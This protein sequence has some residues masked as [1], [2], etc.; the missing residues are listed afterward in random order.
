MSI[1]AV[2]YVVSIAIDLMA[3]IEISDRFYDMRF[4]LFA[5]A[6]ADER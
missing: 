4:L 6:V 3:D 5:D 1:S 2:T